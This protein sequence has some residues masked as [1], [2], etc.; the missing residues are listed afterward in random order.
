MKHITGAKKLA[1]IVS[2][3]AGARGRTIWLEKHGYATKD[4]FNIT[5]EFTV[6]NKKQMA[7]VS[8]L[9]QSALN[10]AIYGGDG[11]TLTCILAKE[12]LKTSDINVLEQMGSE[13]EEVKHILDC[14]KK[15]KL[16]KKDLY[17]VAYTSSNGDKEVAEKVSELVWGIGKDGLLMTEQ[18]HEE[19]LNVD[20]VEGFTFNSGYLDGAF[21][22]SR[23]GSS[24]HEKP[25]IFIQ[26][27]YNISDC[28][29]Y[30]EQAH[31]EKR[32]LVLFG[33]PDDQALL[34]ITQNHMQGNIVAC[35]VAIN[36]QGKSKERF[37][38]D[39]REVLK[40]GCE[41]IIVKRHETIIK[42][43]NDVSGYIET[44]QEEDTP[45]K[46]EKDEQKERIARLTGKIGIIK[47]GAKT[48]AEE[49]ERIDR[50][51]DSVRACQSALEDGI[52]VG[53]GMALYNINMYHKNKAYGIIDKSLKAQYKVLCKNAKLKPDGTQYN[54]R[55][56]QE[57]DLM[58]NG[59][60]DS[61]KCIKL[62]LDNAYSVAKELMKLNDYVMEV[63]DD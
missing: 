37:V 3:T 30:L 26:E 58:E 8:I 7:G 50:I 6:K 57:C 19:G 15:S 10:T 51:E 23:N 35:C 41:K 31:V 32:P 1:N 17:N 9:K 21:V 33:I 11:T 46:H 28:K 22:N 62:A 36:G 39:L 48:Q 13:I 52:V 14:T 61:V 44:L 20:I 59:I 54:L 40:N 45:T 56:R 12:M 2:K 34:G 47:T 53:G 29:S 49:R 4:G 60:V 43:F 5:R 16:T 38:N 18:S 25:I 63:K 55:T 24:E 27:R 42:G